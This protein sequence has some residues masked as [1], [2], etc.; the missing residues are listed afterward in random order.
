MATLDLEVSARQI[1]NTELELEL[2]FT[3]IRI[4]LHSFDIFV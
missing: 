2:E 3:Y 4:D 1:S